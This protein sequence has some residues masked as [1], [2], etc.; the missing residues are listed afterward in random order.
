MGG[1]PIPFAA[2]VLLP[3]SPQVLTAT[4][5]S[6]SNTLTVAFDR[7][8]V[9]GPVDETNWVCRADGNV[10][11][12]PSAIVSGSA[13]ILPNGVAGAASAAN[14]V[15]YSPPPFDVLGVDGTVAQ[16][17]TFSPVNVV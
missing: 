7:S 17:F 13:V 6:A 16:P 5:A 10:Y 8:L 14:E 3:S 4:F 11:T 2:S 12:F 9:A 15:V 1:C